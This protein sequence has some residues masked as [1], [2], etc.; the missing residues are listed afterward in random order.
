MI[1][2]F[3]EI[4]NDVKTNGVASK[5]IK[6]VNGLNFINFDDVHFICTLE[7]DVK[8]FFS[9]KSFCYDVERNTIQVYYTSLDN[10]EI[11]ATNNDDEQNCNEIHKLSLNSDIFTYHKFCGLIHLIME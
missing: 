1:K 5:W 11:L 6:N 7:M 8:D 4:M 10:L 2:K 3:D 9:H